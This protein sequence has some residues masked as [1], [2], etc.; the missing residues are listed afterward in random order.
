MLQ[1]PQPTPNNICAAR[2]KIHSLSHEFK[3][4]KR[5]SVQNSTSPNDEHHASNPQSS[6]TVRSSHKNKEVEEPLSQ[7][8]SASISE[9]VKTL[10][11]ALSLWLAV[12]PRILGRS[13]ESGKENA[14]GYDHVARGGKDSGFWIRLP[15]DGTSYGVV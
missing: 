6:P 4:R 5:K 15:N 7:G 14:N 9:A 3:T 10:G 12:G 11:E 2:P 1:A 8:T 13:I